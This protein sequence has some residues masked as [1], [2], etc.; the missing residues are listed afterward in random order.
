[1]IFSLDIKTNFI[2]AKNK[3]VKNV[4]I[5]ALLLSITIIADTLLITYS[6]NEYLINLIFTVL[7]SILFSFYVI[8]DLTIIYP[9][10]NN[11]LRFFK[12]YF[13]GEKN[14]DIVFVNSFSESKTIMNGLESYKVNITVV[15]GLLKEEK[16]IFVF[17]KF[18]FSKNKKYKI[19]TYQRI[20]T[21]IE[22]YD[23]NK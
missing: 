10:L 13:S 21:K 19:E 23:S 16:S 14:S 4:F 7:I 8:F 3:M 17:S 12:G 22:E 15:D 18:N 2:N 6:T 11:E 9:K 20:I 1:M 5:F